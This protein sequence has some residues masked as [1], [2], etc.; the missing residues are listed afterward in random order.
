ME[1]EP[2]MGKT[3]SS[4]KLPCQRMEASFYCG[5]PD[6]AQGQLIADTL[7]FAVLR[8]MLHL[9]GAKSSP[10]VTTLGTEA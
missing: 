2:K 5:V 10:Y 8:G 7:A 6:D 9:G 3:S 1:G 4:F